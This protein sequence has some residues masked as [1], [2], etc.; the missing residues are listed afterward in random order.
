MAKFTVQF[1][2]LAKANLPLETAAARLAEGHHRAG[3]RVLIL[4]GDPAQ[5]QALDRTLWTF[6][7][8]SF[9]PHGVAGQDGAEDEPVLIAL[10]AAGAPA[11]QVLI[12]AHPAEIQAPSGYQ[13]IIDFVP[14]AQ[15]PALDAARERYRTWQKNPGATLEHLTRVPAAS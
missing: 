2:N 8:G 6:D 11:A 12:L 9:L 14:A 15:G 4:A 13:F 5:A 10:Q 1:I 7:P 3:R